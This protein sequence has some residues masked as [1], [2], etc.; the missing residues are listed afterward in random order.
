VSDAR[1]ELVARVSR[2]LELLEERI[3]LAGRDP[4]TVAVVAVT[5]TFGPDA[6]LA[7]AAAGIGD[8]GENY[9]DEL[10]RTHDAAQGAALTWHF[11][12]A[13][14]RNK[15]AKLAGRVDVYQTIASARE[16]EALAARAPGARAYVQVDVAGLPGRNG[17]GLDDVPGI[18]AASRAAGLTVEGLMCVGS[19]DPS[20]VEG[21]F[22]ALR[23]AADAVG[24][25][26]CSMGMSGDLEAA[27]RQGSTMLRVGTALFG[28]RRR[29]PGR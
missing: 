11:L 27:C 29:R 28:E 9:A 23:R 15:L 10:V 1:D 18:V 22:G 13:L 14:Q 16:A 17:C 24:L 19:P 8:V 26:G 20:I 21:E 3:A 5:K 4:A 12:G 2:N 25:E 7:A 6:A